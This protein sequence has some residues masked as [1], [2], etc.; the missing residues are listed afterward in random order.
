[1]GAQRLPLHC[2]VDFIPNHY[3]YQKKK[4]LQAK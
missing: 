1:L 3:W 4:Y 2:F